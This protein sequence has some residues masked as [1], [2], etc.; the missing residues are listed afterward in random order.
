MSKKEEKE[1]EEEEEEEEGEE[2][3][4]QNMAVYVL[5]VNYRFQWKQGVLLWTKHRHVCTI[6]YV[7]SILIQNVANNETLG[8]FFS[9]L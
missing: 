9:F 7:F 1:E 3:K 8:F 6:F 5:H 2:E 4:K